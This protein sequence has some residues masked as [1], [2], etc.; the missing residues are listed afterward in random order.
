MKIQE[1]LHLMDTE[2]LYIDHLGADK[3]EFKVLVGQISKMLENG[4]FS[5]LFCHFN[6]RL[7]LKIEISSQ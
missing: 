6:W 7:C 5:N 4:N 3:I 1:I 2:I